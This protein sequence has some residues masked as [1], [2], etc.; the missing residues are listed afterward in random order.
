[1]KTS[2]MSDA[3]GAVR[4]AVDL[5]VLV[6]NVV[7]TMHHNIA[8]RPGILGV[9]ATEP[10][11]GVTGIVYRS[12][13]GVTRGV[14]TAIDVALRPLEPLLRMPSGPAREAVL[15]ALNGVLGDHLEA[16]ANP[17]AIPMQLRMHGA[18]LPLDRG[19]LAAILPQPSARVIVMVHGLCMSD[20]TWT[21]DGHDH[22]RE[23]ARDL[24]A[25]LVCLRYNSGRH[26][27]TNGNELATLLEAMVAA[28]PVPLR[29]LV[30][31]GHSMGGLVIRSA[32]AAG[33][34]AG[35]AWPRM[36][37]ALVFLGTPHH[38]AP[39]ERA[40]HAIDTLLGASP[41]TIAFARLGHMRSAGITDLRHGSVL[42]EDWRDRDRFGRGRQVRS[43]APLPRDVPTFAIA[44]STSKARPAGRAIARGDGLVPVASALGQRHGHDPDIGFDPGRQ[45]VAYGVGH[46]DLLAS[47]AVYAQLKRWITASGPRSPRPRRPR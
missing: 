44:G 11:R 18:P 46:L 24:R 26:I 45:W 34:D 36:L 27:S 10:A 47:S 6:M 25:N 14:G 42:E 16:S 35:H 30:L 3:R 41:Y 2:P 31:V 29:E 17:L 20:S 28:W 4:L 32:C 22:G 37:R 13:R 12:V 38:G 19:K 1:M 5:A 9:A 23:L 43:N 7:E 15:S 39:L 8:R 33:E 40:G 21:R